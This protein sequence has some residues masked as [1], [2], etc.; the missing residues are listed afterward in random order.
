MLDHFYRGID[1][2]SR[3]APR[4]FLKKVV[5]VYAP[6]V[7][8]GNFLGNIVFASLMGI[9]PARY[10]KNYHYGY[11]QVDTYGADYRFLLDKGVMNP[12]GNFDDIRNS[13]STL[14]SIMKEAELSEDPASFIDMLKS[15]AGAIPKGLEYVYQNVDQWGKMA[16]FRSLVELKVHPDEAARRVAVGFQNLRKVGKAYTI[17]SKMPLIGQPFA[18]FSGDLVRILGT[19]AIKNPLNMITF[20][21]TLQGMQHFTS[22]MSD[23]TEE[24]RRVRMRKS[25]IPFIPLPAWAGGDISLSFRLGKQA[26]NLARFVSPMFT[27]AGSGGESDYG[28]VLLKLAPWYPDVAPPVNSKFSFGPHDPD[29][30]D[31]IKMFSKDIL[32]GTAIQ[33]MFDSDFMGNSTQDNTRDRYNKKGSKT[34]MAKAAVSLNFLA[35][36]YIPYWNMV[37]DIYLSYTRGEDHYGRK[38][39]IA[40]SIFRYL[41]YNGEAVDNEYYD[42]IISKDYKPLLQEI[43]DNALHINAIVADRFG[44]IESLKNTPSEKLPEAMQMVIAGNIYKNRNKAGELK[45][46]SPDEM[47]KLIQAI[48]ENKAP[49]EFSQM[50]SLSEENFKESMIKAINKQADDLI[51]LGKKFKEDESVWRLKDTKE[52]T[53]IM[54]LK[55]FIDKAEKKQAANEEGNK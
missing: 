25:G 40:M 12:G 9:N 26:V 50:F 54:N 2:Y 37:N 18:R 21:A 27:Y 38:K 31:I 43:E 34:G 8:G 6:A 39:S 52:L 35:R 17:A 42:K 3:W 7:Q 15:G 5:T 55:Y 46:I 33:W 45:Y 47:Q 23:E 44:T 36:G 13:V 29:Y 1:A 41:G 48:T 4:Q 10:L 11:K 20:L 51:A 19:S 53:K 14:K 16:A 30:V 24:E 28:R 22:Y 49:A 32:P